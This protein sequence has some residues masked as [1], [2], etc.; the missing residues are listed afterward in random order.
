M[1]KRHWLKGIALALILSNVGAAQGAPERIAFGATALSSVHYTYSAAA[2]KAINEKVGDKL[3]VTVMATGGAVDNLQRIRRGQINFGLGTYATIYQAYKGI[4][5][6]EGQANPKLR[7]LWV[8]S[9]AM[10]AWV[11]RKDSGIKNLQDLQGK[12]FTPGQRGSA[13]EQLVIQMLE[14]LDIKPQLTRMSLSDAVDAL[15]NGR[16][17]GYA[18]AGGTASLDGTTLEVLATTPLNNLS[19]TPEQVEQIRTKLPFISF[20]T[21]KDGQ[22]E[23]FPAFTT[24]VQVV[25]EFTTSDGMTEE[26][27]MALLEGIVDNP[28]PQ[29]AAFPSFGK[30]DVMQDSVDLISIPLHA[31]AVKFYRSRGI[32]VPE[33]LVPPEIK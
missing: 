21:L 6:F 13:T 23:G 10:Q 31:G 12:P 9:P 7:G 14:A 16:T 30:L 3:E 20:Q 5:K 18:K 1:F 15:K 26:Q 24:P 22:I 2:T 19:F 4:G 28:D 8:H 29:V 17:L 25:G 32:E 33:R 27:V 11:V